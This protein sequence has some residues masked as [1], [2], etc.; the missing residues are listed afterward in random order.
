MLQGFYH[1][2]SKPY[3][4]KVIGAQGIDTPYTMAEIKHGLDLKRPEQEMFKSDYT[5]SMYQGKYTGTLR[6]GVGRGDRHA[7]L[8]KM[9]MLSENVASQKIMQEKKH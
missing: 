6:Y 8:V 1:N 5:P 7:A 2:K 9:L 4:I 3:P